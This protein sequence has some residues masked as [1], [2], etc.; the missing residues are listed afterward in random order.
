M[1]KCEAILGF[2]KE[3][4]GGLKTHTHSHKLRHL[5][6]MQPS[7]LIPQP[8]LPK[9]TGSEQKLDGALEPESLLRGQ[10]VGDGPQLYS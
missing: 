5:W 2:V 7:S 4:G 8:L 3:E 9:A 6:K 10:L 1:Q